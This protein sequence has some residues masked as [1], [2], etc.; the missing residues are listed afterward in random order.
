MSEEKWVDIHGYEGWYQ[1]SNL[2]RVRSVDREIEQWSRYGHSIIRKVKGRVIAQTD[3]GHGYLT[4][5][6]K[7][8]Q[9]GENHYVHRLV[10]EAFIENGDNLPEVNHIDYDKRNNSVENLEWVSRVSNIAHS[11]C[12]MRGPRAGARLPKTGHRYVQM[13]KGK[14]RLV[15]KLPGLRFDRSFQTLK[16]A[17]E[18]R[19]VIMSGW[20]HYANGAGMFR[21]WSN[22]NA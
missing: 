13:R 20:Q 1:V 4:V 7:K 11:A 21:N 19:E 14:Y 10:A 5:G 15:I 6:L 22:K 16:E 18:K 12:R 17:L 9:V 3:N 8:N 2:G